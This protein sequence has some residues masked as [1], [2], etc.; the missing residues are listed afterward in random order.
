MTSLPPPSPEA[1]F[2][3]LVLAPATFSRNKYFSLFQNEAGRHARRRAQIVR[4]LLRDLA[5]TL[6]HHTRLRPSATVVS[7]QE[8]PEGLQLC[9]QIEELELQRSSQL[10][11]LEAAT[12]RYALARLQGVA[13]SPSDELWVERALR[14]LDP[15]EELKPHLS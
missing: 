15:R 4:S 14:Q 8:G 1:L 11:P 13:P 7:E 9:Y 12:F 2:V 5:P 10:N 6:P 3:A